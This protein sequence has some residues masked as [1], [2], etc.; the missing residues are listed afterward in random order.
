MTDPKGL[1]PSAVS[2]TAIELSNGDGDGIKKIKRVA[3]FAEDTEETASSETL[4]REESAESDP[5][6]DSQRSISEK[7]TW[8]MHQVHE[9]QKQ[10]ETYYQFLFLRADSQPV[11]G[12]QD[13]STSQWAKQLNSHMD[14]ANELV[15]H[16]LGPEHTTGKHGSRSHGLAR[17]IKER[18]HDPLPACAVRSRFVGYGTALPLRRASLLRTTWSPND[19]DPRLQVGV[20]G[21]DRV[22]ERVPERA[23]Q[24]GAGSA[25]VL[26]ERWRPRLQRLPAGRSDRRA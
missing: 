22:P 25:H 4:R 6:A 3:T 23:P 20:E 14:Q 16:M 19:R 13:W 26:H 12:L 21:G 1:P 8:A 15:K 17:A 2:Q 11:V 10:V 7:S 9:V 5:I 24:R 18:L